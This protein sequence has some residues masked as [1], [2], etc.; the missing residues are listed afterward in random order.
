V[1][2][3]DFILSERRTD[4]LLF[5]ENLSARVPSLNDEP[6]FAGLPILNR[7]KQGQTKLKSFLTDRHS[8]DASLPNG[9]EVR[10]RCLPSLD[11]N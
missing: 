7:K 1:V 10:Q 2:G 5:Q 8:T 3:D 4:L 9:C 11:P 6:S